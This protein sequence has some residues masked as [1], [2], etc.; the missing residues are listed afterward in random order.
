MPRILSLALAALLLVTTAANA[1][2]PTKGR[3]TKTWQTTSYG[4]GSDGALQNGLL[5]MF[6]DLGNGVVKDQRTGLFWEKKSD[7]GSIHDKDNAYTW[8][9]NTAPYLMNG[10]TVTVLVAILNTPPC[11]AG[12]CDW[13]IPNIKELETLRDL[14]WYDPATFPDLDT[15][16]TPGCPVTA[17]SCTNSGSYWSSSTGVF[18]PHGAWFVNFST[19][20]SDVGDKASLR[21]ARA[22]RGG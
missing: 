17:C 18:A 7:D 9:Q 15:A 20:G 6:A 5:P 16:C 4:P 21:H 12:Y 22:V 1:T 2:R 8:G 11:F 13:R 19:G 14:G 3:P 10:T